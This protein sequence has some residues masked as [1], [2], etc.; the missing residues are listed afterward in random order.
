MVERMPAGEVGDRVVVQ[1]VV[2]T[3]ALDRV[4]VVR[5]HATPPYLRGS[6]NPSAL[7]RRLA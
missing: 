6:P 2:P 7:S 4:H 3:A 5:A 1:Q